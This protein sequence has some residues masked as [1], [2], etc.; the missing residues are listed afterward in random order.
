MRSNVFTFVGSES[1]NPVYR[2]RCRELHEMAMVSSIFNIIDDNIKQY[3]INRV[4]Q[5]KLIV[6]DMTG[7]ED[8][9][10]KGC[11]ELF[12]QDTPVEGAQLVIEHV[13]IKARC[14]TCGNEFVVQNMHYKCANCGNERIS[15]IS[16]K[17]L[18]IDSIEAE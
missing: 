15:I 11:F 6:G 8:M 7:V 4:I 16:G 17:E 12:A 18:Y 2:K 9:T 1:K 5:V 10:M 13:P 3:N 14:R